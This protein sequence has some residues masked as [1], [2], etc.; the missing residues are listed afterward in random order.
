MTRRRLFDPLFRVGSGLLLVIGLFGPLEAT[1]HADATDD[2]FLSALK[3]KGIKFGSSEKALVAAHEVCDELDNGKSPAQVASTVQSNSDL[4]GYH[5]G[6]F[7]G[8]S[9]RAYCPRYAS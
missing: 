9:I 7:V 8:A 5:A 6:F 3:A 4:D 2:A 1:A